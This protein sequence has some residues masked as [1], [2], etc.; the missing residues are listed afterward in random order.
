MSY[1][2]LSGIE[3]DFC[4]ML[5]CETC[6]TCETG[7]SKQ[8]DDNLGGFLVLTIHTFNLGGWLPFRMGDHPL[9]R[10]VWC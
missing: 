8:V 4:W 5:R 7:L 9:R 10:V 3:A 1:H 2:S 6:N